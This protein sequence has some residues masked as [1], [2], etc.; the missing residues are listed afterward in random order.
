MSDYVGPPLGRERPA[1]ELI[2]SRVTTSDID[3]PVC[4]KPATA[5][6]FW[7]EDG[8]NGVAC[9]EHGIEAR[10]TWRIYDEHAVGGVCTMPMSSWVPSWEDPPGRCVWLVSDETLA[11]AQAAESVPA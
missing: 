11:L 6:L 1:G 3:G 4:G 9:D 10:A 8:E 7:D 5:H 2:C